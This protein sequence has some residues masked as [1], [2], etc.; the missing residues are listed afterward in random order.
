MAGY[1]LLGY[2]ATKGMSMKD[3]IQSR[4][5]APDSVLVSQRQNEHYAR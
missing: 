2:C 5:P 1:V 4:G 3:T